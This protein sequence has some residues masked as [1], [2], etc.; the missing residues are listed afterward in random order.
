VVKCLSIDLAGR[1][2]SALSLH[3]GWVQTEMGGPNAEITT[4]ESV[5]GL[6]LVLQAAG[7]EQNGQFL[8]YNGAPIPW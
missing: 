7:P 6:K 1:G 5:A 2:I 3:P 4:A 8:E